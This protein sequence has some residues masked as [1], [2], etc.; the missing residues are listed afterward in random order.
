MSFFRKKRH[1]A[2]LLVI[3]VFFLFYSTDWIGQLIYPIHFK[4]DIRI[5]SENYNVDPLLVAAIIRV[6]S[7]YVPDKVSVKN[8]QGLMQIMPN[9]ADWLVELHDLNPLGN[10]EL[11][12]ADVNIE[13]GALYL[14]VLSRQ[15]EKQLNGASDEQKVAFLA[16]AYNAGPGNVSAWMKQNI[17]DGSL[18]GVSQIPYGE[19]RHYV[20]RV[21]YYYNKYQHFY[22]N[23]F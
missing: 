18:D 14:S 17:W 20:R 21:L 6:E 15:F 22:E 13:I 16:A 12:R 9:T 3:F 7:N 4:E 11:L 10:D 19:T 23:E 5:S 1:Y 2:L 8:A